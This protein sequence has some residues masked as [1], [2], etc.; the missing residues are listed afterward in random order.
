MPFSAG[1]VVI[2][3]RRMTGNDQ[4]EILENHVH[5]MILQGMTSF[6]KVTIYFTQ[7]DLTSLGLESMTTKFDISLGPPLTSVSQSY[8]GLFWKIVPG[9]GIPP[10]SLRELSLI[11]PCGSGII[12]CCHNPGFFTIQFLDKF[13]EFSMLNIVLHYNKDVSFISGYIYLITTCVFFHKR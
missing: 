4:A 5:L 11:F 7:L 13:W 1:S 10:T 9:A 3:Q 2:L 12:Y 6:R 8:R